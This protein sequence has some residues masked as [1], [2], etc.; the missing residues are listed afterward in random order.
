MTREEIYR[1]RYE[2]EQKKEEE[3]QATLLMWKRH[4]EAVNRRRNQGI[5]EFYKGFYSVASKAVHDERQ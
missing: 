4:Y 2:Q 3:D 5:T 1:A